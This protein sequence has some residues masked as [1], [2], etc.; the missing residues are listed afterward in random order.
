MEHSLKQDKDGDGL[1][2][3]SGAADQ[4]FDGWCV[5]GPRLVVTRQKLLVSNFCIYFCG[6][7][8]QS[9]PVRSIPLQLG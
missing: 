3:N 1:I 6:I 5:L 4:T 9:F 7:F 2:E 8:G